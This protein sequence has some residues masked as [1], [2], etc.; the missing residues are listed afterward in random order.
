MNFNKQFNKFYPILEEIAKRYARTTSVPY[1]EYESSLSE[2]F[3]LKY[4]DFDP[5][6]RNNFN[7]FMRVVLTQRASRVANR[8]EG[9]FYDRITYLE[10]P[11]NDIDSD[12]DDNDFEIASEWDLEEHV[13]SNLEKKTDEDK[14]QLINA[15][16]RKTDSTT[17]LIVDEYLRSEYARPTAIGKS[18]GIHH[19]TVI[20]KISRLSRNFDESK[21]GDIDAYL[22]S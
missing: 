17:K 19:Q 7:A 3:Y 22:A 16:I 18:L 15:L 2:E 21:F 10:T 14:L 1:E 20:R 11:S 9:S 5:K 8:A 12:E 13:I 4:N 6:K